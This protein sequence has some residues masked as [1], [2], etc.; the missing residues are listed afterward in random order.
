VGTLARASAASVA[1]TV[2][3]GVVYQAVLLALRGR[4]GVAAFAGALVGAVASFSLSRWWAF[5]TSGRRLGEQA[6]TY[7]GAS[8]ATWL[9]LQLGLLLLIEGLGVHERVAWVPAKVVAWAAVSYPLHRFVV[10]AKRP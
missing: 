2:L 8:F 3:D 4:W 9:A 7:A 6:L 1:A 5:P 10:F